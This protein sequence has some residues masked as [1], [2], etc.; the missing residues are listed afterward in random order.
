MPDNTAE[1]KDRL[2][3]YKRNYVYKVLFLVYHLTRTAILQTRRYFYIKLT[4]LKMIL[5]ARKAAKLKDRPYDVGLGPIPLISHI[6]HK[7]A[8]AKYGYKTNTFVNQ[9]YFITNEF[10]FNSETSF[11]EYQ[12]KREYYLTWFRYVVNNH[13]CVYIYFNGCVLGPSADFRKYEAWLYKLAKVKVVVMPYGGDIQDFART[14]N[15]LFKN[16]MSKD[17]PKFHLQRKM[18]RSNVEMWTTHADHI[19][20]GCDWVE[21][22]YHWDTLTLAHFSIDTERWKPSTDRVDKLADPGRPF[23]IFHA[24]NHRNVKGSKHF[25]RAV[26]ELK[27]EGLNVELVILQKVPNDQVR[28]VIEEVDVVADQL[29]V[30]WYAMFALEAMCLEKPVL[31]Y[32]NPDIEKLYIEEGLVQPGEIPIVKCDPFTVKETIR[33]LYNNRSKLREIGIRSRQFAIKHHS[34][35]YIGS[36]FDKINKTIGLK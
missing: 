33:D 31:C 24:P 20:S 3:L 14:K 18:I 19:I 35:D 25:I 10:D 29:I 2:P 8:L 6:Y 32:L 15:L 30:G 34:T 11:T 9:V 26:E 5:A 16:A 23:K 36:V 28:K 12:K 21:Y 1:E 22:M 4:L 17:Y 13:K 27:Q 7:Q